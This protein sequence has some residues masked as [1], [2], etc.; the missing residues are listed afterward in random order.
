VV[1]ETPPLPAAPKPTPAGK[2]PVGTR[3]EV[4]FYRGDHLIG[5]KQTQ[6]GS[7][8]YALTTCDLTDENSGTMS[9]V[10]G[11]EMQK[12]GSGPWR[13]LSRDEEDE[14]IG[15]QL[16]AMK[17]SLENDAPGV[18]CLGIAIQELSNTVVRP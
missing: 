8:G 1:Q 2:A 15:T 10:I 7:D 3:F 5:R 14:P 9:T 4:S 12:V 18:T 6:I 13:Y 16:L 11:P 17:R